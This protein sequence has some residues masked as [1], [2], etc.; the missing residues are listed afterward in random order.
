MCVK[1]DF[2]KLPENK[3]EYEAW[4][5]KMAEQEIEAAKTGKVTCICNITYGLMW[6]YRCYY[7]GLWLCPVCAKKHFG[8]RPKGKYTYKVYFKEDD[9]EI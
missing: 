1:Y 5:K 9:N 3:Q 4:M 2:H 7:C 6:L 8:K